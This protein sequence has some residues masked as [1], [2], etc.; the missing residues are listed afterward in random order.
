M[1]V[2]RKRLSDRLAENLRTLIAEGKIE[3]G[4]YLPPERTLERQFKVSR[5]TVRRA[6]SSLV[7]EGLI[8]SVPSCGYRPVRERPRV[9]RG[10]LAY[11]L[12]A[13][14]PGD[15][16]DSSHARI[17]AAFNRAA[18]DR[19]RKLL[20]V[21]AHGRDP[22]ELYD[23]LASNDLW[24][25]VL[26]SC[27]L[28]LAREAMRRGH[29]C[30]VVDAFLD[31]RGVDV[32]LQDNF[33]G[34]RAATEYLLERGH[35]AIGWVGTS[36]LNEAERRRLDT[37][38]IGVGSEG[39]RNFVHYRERFAGTMAAMY[40]YGKTFDPRY[41]VD[42]QNNEARD[43]AR[44]KV[45]KLLAAKNRPSALVCMWQQIALGAIQAVRDAGLKIGSDIEL[46]FWS[47]EEEYRE[48]F[49]PEFLGESVPAAVLWRPQEMAELALQRLEMRAAYPHAPACRTYVAT[50]LVEPQ[51]AE[52]V[53]RRGAKLEKIW[54]V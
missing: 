13:V 51:P 5:V 16:W 2:S 40:D 30:V 37:Q 3:D 17:F 23:E 1:K 7:R 26:D 25:V 15:P 29:P 48:T 28:D 34:A 18:F 46:V 50:R 11:V 35:E 43:E 24:G 42:V 10:T 38:T 45:A 33:N 14:G 27:W 31:H 20:G 41:L 52:D 9:E 8:E 19:R 47:S 32:V 4:A 53:L 21:G 49:A 12:S 6:L 22:A 54:D 39:G 44:A 36:R